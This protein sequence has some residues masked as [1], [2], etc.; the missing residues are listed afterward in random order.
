[1][2]AVPPPLSVKVIPPGSA[3]DSVRVGVGKPVA[4]TVSACGGPSAALD[5][6]IYNG[7]G[8]H[9]QIAPIPQ[10]WR[11]ITMDGAD[12]AYRDST[13]D[14]SVL[15]NAH[16]ESTHADTPLQAL[17][18]QLVMGTTE[19]DFSSQTTEPFD[20]REALH[21]RLAAKLAGA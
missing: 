2:V 8:A 15:V 19:R 17:T 4:V 13:N 6:S 7:G 16:C 20:G 3:P 21:S 12:I 5:G 14:A 10:T 11:R 1:M 9:F 18:N